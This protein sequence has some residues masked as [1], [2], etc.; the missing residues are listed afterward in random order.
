MG[1]E[2]AAALSRAP[3]QLLRP[4]SQRP[5]ASH[6]CRTGGV[7]PWSASLARR[8]PSEVLVGVAGG[9]VSDP[10]VRLR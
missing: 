1:R 4:P 2:M 5:G 6:S 9:S 8:K 3:A 10:P 7:Y